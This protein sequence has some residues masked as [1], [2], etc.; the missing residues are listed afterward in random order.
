MAELILGVDYNISAAEAKQKKLNA[1]WEQQ[2]IKIQSIEKEISEM[3]IS[4]ADMRGQQADITEEYKKTNSE[5]IRLGEVVDKINAGTATLQEMID[6]GG[7]EKAQSDYAN[8]IKSLDDINSRY[9]KI[10]ANINRKDAALAKTNVSLNYEE[11]NLE[12]IGAKILDLSNK[13]KRAGSSWNLFKKGTEKFTASILKMGRRIKELIKYALFFAL[14]TKAFTAMRENLGKIIGQDSKIMEQWKQ[15]KGIFSV[16]GAQLFQAFRP[17]IEWIL[18]K[19]IMIGNVITFLISKMTGKSVEDSKKIA[20]NAAKTADSTKKTADALK[21]ATAGFD[22]LQ[23]ATGE[24][25]TNGAE[26]GVSGSL[27]MSGIQEI[28]E[29]KFSRIIGFVS[30][31][32]ELFSQLS[33]ILG[34]LWDKIVTPFISFSAQLVIDLLGLI[35][36]ALTEFSEWCNGE[37]DGI[38][39]TSSIVLGFLAGLLFYLLT[40]TIID[41]VKRFTAAIIALGNGSLIAGLKIAFVAAALG[42][43]AA[44]II[45]CASNWNKMSGAQKAITVLGSLAA[46]ATAAAIAIAIFHTTWTVGLAAAGIALGLAALGLTFAFTK[47]KSTSD[48]AEKAANGFYSSYDWNKTMPIPKLAT[49]AVIPGGKPF[50]AMLGDQ[51]SGQTNIEAPLDTIVEAVKLAIG[52][53]HFSIEATGSMAQLIRFLN[54]EVKKED[55]RSTVF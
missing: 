15:L 51:K 33:P 48:T 30:Q 18:E 35:V 27:D 32:K 29:S 34:W 6:V 1:Q 55:R 37:R 20:K 39:L 41:V 52:E 54:L 50:M 10:T 46:A 28:D 40:K 42:I 19:A 8:A 53:P 12:I 5:A 22:T 26:D 25:V 24:T 23:T 17:A 13:T 44:G 45:Y 7:A 9:D 21:K 4:L 47:N 2:K 14:I 16:I 43:L 38:S 49:G 3:N 31:I 11:A 36:N